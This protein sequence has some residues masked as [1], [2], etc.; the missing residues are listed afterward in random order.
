M[1]VD[2]LPPAKRVRHVPRV[3][4]VDDHDDLAASLCA[5]LSNAVFEGAKADVARTA[6]GSEALRVA[7]GY[8]VM[9]VDIKLPDM[10]GVE[11]LREL[12]VRNAA[13]EVIVIT[14]FAT[15]D[16]AVDALH[17]GAFAFIEKTFR[18]NELTATV[19]QALNKVR[20]HHERFELEQRYRALVELTDVMV[21]ELDAHGR[22][23]FFN[24]KALT[25]AGHDADA[26]SGRDFLSSW[27]VP[28]ERED[29]GTVI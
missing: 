8:D 12:K 24:Q 13:S 21:V 18:P 29:V 1:S 6:T 27:I 4:V 17:S 5:V 2:S 25:L 10:S 11:L 9:I 16:A 22:V 15:K 28:E 14:G 23:V 3:L 26:V 7:D 19:A 20:L